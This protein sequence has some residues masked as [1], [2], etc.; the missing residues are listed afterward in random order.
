MKYNIIISPETIDGDFSTVQYSGETVGVYSAMTSILSGNTNGTS[1]LTG[2]TIP[3]LLT[4][5]VKD[6]GYYDPFDGA[7]LQKDIVTNFIFSATTG[8]PYTVNVYNT[9]EDYQKFLSLSSYEVDW[10]DSS[11][12]QQITN[13]SP[14]FITHNYAGQNATYNIT[15]TQN[16]PWGVTRVTKNITLPFTNAI[17]SNPKGN[18]IFISNSGN[19]SATPINYSFIFSGDAYNDVQSQ[20]SSNFTTVPY[21]VSGSAV[22]R[23]QDLEQYGQQKYIQGKPIYKNRRLYGQVN[24]IDPQGLFTGYTIEGIDYYDFSD[25]TTMFYMNSSGFTTDNLVAQPITKQDVLMGVVDQ[26]QIQTDVYIERG[27]SSGYERLQRLGEVDNL[28]D[29][30]NY[31]YGFFNIVRKD[32]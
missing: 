18:A 15:L 6:V 29:L 24:N 17:I 12:L 1:F 8:S 25:G 32:V 14:N 5:T 22:S 2:L 31:G 3:I 30:E 10:G 26:P 21:I 19:W 7:V 9:S 13:F 23:L 4:Q 16:N 28:G 20:V 11:P 27:K